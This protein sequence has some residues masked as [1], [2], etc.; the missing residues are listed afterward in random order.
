MPLE[1]QHAK[2][3]ALF[4]E[5]RAVNFGAG[6]PDEHENLLDILEIVAVLVGL[7]P[8]HLQGQGQH[9]EA[10][11]LALTEIALRH[12]LLAHQSKGFAEW[13]HRPYRGDQSF[14]AWMDGPERNGDWQ[15]LWVY[16]EPQLLN[17][18]GDVVEGVRRPGEAL[19]YPECCERAHSE[20]AL[21][22]LEA[23]ER[24][25]REEYGARSTD[26]L[27][28]CALQDRPVA[29]DED[30]D[31]ELPALLETYPFIQFIACSACAKS[32]G[33]AADRKNN[34]MRILAR[35]LDASF[36]KAIAAGSQVLLRQP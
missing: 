18:I 30:P 17:V 7:K 2:R 6:K 22:V 19:G 15:V 32:R 23:L 31:A 28:Q 20:R 4:R 21:L 36:S 29:V 25:Y 34:A 9:D 13:K 8:A 1:P 14:Q 16:R 3:M 5:L 24:G 11:S 12:G 27:I 35:N 10:T 33:S 26:E